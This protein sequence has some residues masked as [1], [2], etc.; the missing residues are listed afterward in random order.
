[1][2]LRAR[3]DDGYLI[4]DPPPATKR[5]CPPSAAT[6]HRLYSPARF[7][8]KKRSRPSRDQSTPRT[9]RLSAV[10][11]R[12]S[13]PVEGIVNTSSTPGLEPRRNAIAVPSGEKTGP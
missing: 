4:F 12:A 8:E 2:R 10:T 7:D 9:S 11:R 13:P 3:A 5:G 1:M 6:R